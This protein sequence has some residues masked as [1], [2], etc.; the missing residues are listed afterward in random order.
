[1]T[2]LQKKIAT[3]IFGKFKLYPAEVISR[4]N[5]VSKVSDFSLWVDEVCKNDNLRRND[6]YENMDM[7]P[8]YKKDTWKL[9]KAVG[10][11]GKRLIDPN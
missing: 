7:I 2:S 9:H 1:M 5:D 10:T 6:T 4:K 8:T 3:E 11:K